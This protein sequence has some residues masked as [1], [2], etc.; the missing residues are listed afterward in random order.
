MN[1]P[2]IEQLLAMHPTGA[3][4]PIL[5]GTIVYACCGEKYCLLTNDVGEDIIDWVDN[6]ESQTQTQ[7]QIIDDDDNPSNRRRRPNAK[8][9]YK[10]GTI[11][12]VVGQGN[13]KI[14]LDRKSVV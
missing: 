1:Q 10:R 12:A 8:R 13:F 6:P 14:R 2:T 9:T 5:V 4:N 3:N 11:I 7:T